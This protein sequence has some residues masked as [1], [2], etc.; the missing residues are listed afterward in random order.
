MCAAWCCMQNVIPYR[1]TPLRFPHYTPSFNKALRYVAFQPRTVSNLCPVF[2]YFTCPRVLLPVLEQK[3]RILYWV[4]SQA[5]Y[6]SSHCRKTYTRKYIYLIYKAM[7]NIIMYYYVLYCIFVLRTRICLIV[8]AHLT[9][10]LLI[11]H[12]W[13]IPWLLPLLPITDIGHNT[14]RL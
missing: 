5:T 6:S 10:K 9:C 2:A 4:S 7:F 14:A 12:K 1:Y 11:L 8:P 3:H 13:N